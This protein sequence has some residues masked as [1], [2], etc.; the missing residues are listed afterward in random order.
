MQIE[1]IARD[2]PKQMENDVAKMA[3]Q[4]VTKLGTGSS[5]ASEIGRKMNAK[6][7]GYWQ[8]ISYSADANAGFAQ[9]VKQHILLEI[10][11]ET[12]MLI[13]LP[14]VGF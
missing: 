3:E 7:G 2:V 11:G 10:D 6:Y 4:V 1:V 8:V 12:R 13:Y 14:G 5:G 9:H